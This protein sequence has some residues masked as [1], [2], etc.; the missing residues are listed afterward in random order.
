MAVHIIQIFN[1]LNPTTSS[2][3]VTSETAEKQSVKSRLE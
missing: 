2:S 3:K 1:A